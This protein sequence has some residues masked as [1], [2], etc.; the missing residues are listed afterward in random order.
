M[1]LD[2]DLDLGWKKRRGSYESPPLTRF[3]YGADVDD[4]GAVE[5]GMSTREHEMNQ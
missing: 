5:R 4:D 1:F 2:V 3:K